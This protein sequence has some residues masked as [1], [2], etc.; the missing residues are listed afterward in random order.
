MFI[1]LFL[2][3]LLCRPVHAMP[4]P[5]GSQLNAGQRILIMGDS[6]SGKTHNGNLLTADAHRVQWFDPED[7]H[8]K[9]GRLVLTP[10][11]L[12]TYPKLLDD[13]HLRLVI[14]PESYDEEGMGEEAAAVA[15][16]VMDRGKNL[17]SYWGEVGDYRRSS[18]SSLNR[19]F[20]KGRK[21]GIVP[22]FDSQVATDFPLTSRKLATDVYVTSMSHSAELA[23][24]ERQYG[25]AVA[26]RALHWHEW[27]VTH[28]RRGRGIIHG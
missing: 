9:P 5:W 8:L 22:V 28:W 4:Q 15:D 14:T 17:V 18:E 26:D 16:L 27:Q 2:L 20:R 3:S 23:E 7:E 12:L 25:E 11:E 19:L 6:G 1:L 24:I 21:R 13:P 10:A